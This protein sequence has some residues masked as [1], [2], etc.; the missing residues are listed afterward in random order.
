MEPSDHKEESSDEVIAPAEV[1]L[2]E[3]P[4]LPK[5]HIPKGVR[6]NMRQVRDLMKTN[7]L[8]HACAQALLDAYHLQQWAAYAMSRLGIDE[9]SNGILIEYVKL[10]ALIPFQEEAMRDSIRD[11]SLPFVADRILEHMK[12]RMQE[13]KK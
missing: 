1:D 6:Q 9:R 10:K 11:R 2:L 3:L 12:Q 4:D 5:G 7:K 8:A 13:R